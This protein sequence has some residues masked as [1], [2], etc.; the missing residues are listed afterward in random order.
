MFSYHSVTLIEAGGAKI[1]VSSVENS[2]KHE[3]SNERR[4]TRVF[5]ECLRLPMFLIIPLTISVPALSSLGI[6]HEP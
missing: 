4:L 1:D 5:K 2:A 3:S 6:H